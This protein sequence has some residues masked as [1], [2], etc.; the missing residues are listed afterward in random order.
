MKDVRALASALRKSVQAHDEHTGV[1][2]QSR[3]P[4]IILKF[5]IS[6][7]SKTISFN[8]FLEI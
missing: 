4:T 7:P 1:A 2:S 6:K 5:C 8:A 3:A